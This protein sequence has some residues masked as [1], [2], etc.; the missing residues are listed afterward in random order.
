[1][2]RRQSRRGNNSGSDGAHRTRPRDDAALGRDVRAGSAMRA[3]FVSVSVY[4][5]LDCV[6]SPPISLPILLRHFVPH[7]IRLLACLLP[8]VTLL[9][10]RLTDLDTS[11]I[12]SRPFLSAEQTRSGSPRCRPLLHLVQDTVAR[13]SERSAFAVEVSAIPRAEQARRYI[14]A[15]CV[16]LYYASSFPH[17]LLLIFC[18]SNFCFRSSIP[19]YPSSNAY[20]LS[21]SVGWRICTG[22]MPLPW[23]FVLITSGSINE[24]LQHGRT[25][26]CDW[27]E[28]PVENTVRAT[29]NPAL[30]E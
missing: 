20:P 19:C 11:A 5:S 7:A 26:L 21:S 3:T 18:S 9:A 17:A 22:F 13:C 28:H 14:Y 8:P 29:K 30:F 24:T 10:L 6:R 23:F 4:P 15:S 2:R 16:Y 12:F 25:R 1:M 27:T